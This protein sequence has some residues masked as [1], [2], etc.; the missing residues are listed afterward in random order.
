MT[1][2]QQLNQKRTDRIM[3]VSCIS[4]SIVL[5]IGLVCF[6]GA[7]T[8]VFGLIGAAFFLLPF[9]TIGIQK[10]LVHLNKKRRREMTLEQMQAE[11]ISFRENAQ[12]TVRSYAVKLARTRTLIHLQGGFYVLCGILSVSLMPGLVPL[13]HTIAGRL[14]IGFILPM[15]WSFFL[16]MMGLS[17]IPNRDKGFTNVGRNVL[18]DKYFPLLTGCVRRVARESGF[19]G[20]VCAFL[21]DDRN[22]SV[23]SVGRGVMLLFDPILLGVLTQDE[24]TACLRHEFAHRTDPAARIF[25]DSDEKFSAFLR[26][27]CR[28]SD[29]ISSCFS[30]FY[31]TLF[32]RYAM[33]MNILSYAS[34]LGC[35]LAADRAMLPSGAQNAASLLTKLFCVSCYTYEHRWEDHPY[36]DKEYI[37][38]GTE[39]GLNEFLSAARERTERWMSLM[40]KEIPSRSDTHPT[41]AMRLKALGKA[42]PE[43]SFDVPEGAWKDECM[44]LIR[45][46]DRANEEKY[47]QNGTYESIERSAQVIKKWENEGET[48]TSHDYSD[49][50]ANLFRLGQSTRAKELCDRI[51][52][53]STVSLEHALLFRG[54]WRLGHYDDGGIDDLMRYISFDTT[55]TNF[56]YDVIGGYCCRVGLQ[57]ELDSYRK[58]VTEQNETYRAAHAEIAGV[59]N[60]KTLRTLSPYHFK[61]RAQE[62]GLLQLLESVSEGKVYE[63]YLIGQSLDDGREVCIAVIHYDVL[64]EPELQ[65]EIRHRVFLYLQ[66]TKKGWNFTRDYSDLEPNI[67]NKLKK[68]KVFEQK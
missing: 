61:D 43:V 32:A 1:K 63:L 60:R 36:P 66:S 39:N 17:L 49:L 53:E 13:F 5:F 47:S 48:L 29:V 62:E 4:V 50:L 67:M 11:T 40:R 34:A 9:L 12:E 10:L 64:I 65:E 26:E 27:K 2:E 18:N 37:S 3:A 46:N 68:C 7:K 55:G 44:E 8:P 42:V 52:N 16:I 31:G 24:F 6:G 15:I 30:F 59:I 23:T 51:L 58:N 14:I 20:V 25:S 57:E 21:K 28:V 38:H 41:T 19:E 56:A 33:L 22:I 54:Q 35:E 45:L